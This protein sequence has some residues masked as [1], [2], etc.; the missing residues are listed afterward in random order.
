[1]T[2]ARGKR[3]FLDSAWPVK[4]FTRL[5]ELSWCDIRNTC[6]SSRHFPWAKKKRKKSLN[7][8]T[9]PLN[10]GRGRA[11]EGLRA[12]LNEFCLPMKCKRMVW[13][14]IICHVSVTMAQT[15]QVDGRTLRDSAGCRVGPKLPRLPGEIVYLSHMKTRPRKFVARLFVK[16]YFRKTCTCFG[17]PL[18]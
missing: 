11:A 9:L 7:I 1:M 2:V 3:H 10:N 18:R 5:T 15:N 12:I 14:L 8:V 4:L 6:V 16:V 13:S 17:C